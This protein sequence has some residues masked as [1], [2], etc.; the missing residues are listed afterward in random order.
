MR[1]ILFLFA[2]LFFSF[3]LQARAEQRPLYDTFTFYWENDVFAKTDRY[4]TNGLRL[5]WSTPYRAGLN[6]PHLPSWSVP[7]I[8]NLPSLSSDDS[9]R[10]I[11]L[12]LGQ[13]I[14]TPANIR[15]SEPQPNDR[16][17]AGYTYVAAGFHGIKDNARANW[18][19]QAGVIGPLSL[20]DKAT[21]LVHRTIGAPLD[22][23]WSHQLRNEPTLEAIVEYQWRMPPPDTPGGFTYDF[24]PHLGAAAGNVWIYANAGAE[25]RF[26]WEVPRDFGTCPI[27]PGC[28]S[29]TSDEAR[30]GARAF[31]VHFFT[32]VD[33]RAVARNIFLDGNTFRSG[34]SVRKKP[35]V[36]DITAGL[37]LERGRLK[38]SYSYVLR[39]K[40]FE[41]QKHYHLFGSVTVSWTY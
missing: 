12:S 2:V 11:S 18:E 14:Y 31:G 9:R 24:I 10:A 15:T 8:D 35:F 34:P 19:L 33:G 13:A 22:R 4:Y 32:A 29:N 38:A 40:E 30:R 16:P 3:A 6:S 1:R 17:Y 26:G 39:T 27:R 7:I 20:A 36:A 37:A 23:G 5:T 41:G 21:G 25:A 28:E